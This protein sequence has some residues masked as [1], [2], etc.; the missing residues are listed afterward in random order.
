MANIPSLENVMTAR[1][2]TIYDRCTVPGCTHELVEV[3]SAV[4]GVCGRCLSVYKNGGRPNA[5]YHDPTPSTAV[6]L[7]WLESM[8]KADP[9]S[10]IIR[11]S[12]CIQDPPS[13]RPFKINL[14]GVSQGTGRTLGEAVW[15]AQRSCVE[16]AIKKAEQ[17][18]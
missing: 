12:L 18:R 14:S 4:R 5:L 11:I 16:E 15:D 9:D 13:D 17:R 3:E 10:T 8:L 1:T 6:S 7:E 2:V